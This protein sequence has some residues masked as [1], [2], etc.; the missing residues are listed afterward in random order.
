MF[1]FYSVR[2]VIQLTEAAS[3]YISLMYFHNKIHVRSYYLN[4]L[5]FIRL[6]CLCQRGVYVYKYSVPTTLSL[7]KQPY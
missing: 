1:L 6:Q 2:L 7:R 4:R 3:R 5:T